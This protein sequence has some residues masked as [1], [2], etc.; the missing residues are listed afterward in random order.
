V[1]YLSVENLI[2]GWFVYGKLC[3]RSV[4]N[5][6]FGLQ[7]NLTLTYSQSIII[8]SNTAFVL[9]KANGYKETS[10]KYTK[11]APYS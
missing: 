1:C 7:V 9:P 10:E 4:E 3:Q 5:Y 8:V 11:K 2:L 6:P